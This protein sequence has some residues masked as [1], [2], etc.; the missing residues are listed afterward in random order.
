[1]TEDTTQSPKDTG[2]DSFERRFV[3]HIAQRC[4]DPGSRALLRRGYRKTPDT[5][6]T[7]HRFVV[8]W[9]DARHD[10]DR[11]YAT[12]SWIALFGTGRKDLTFGVA[13]RKTAALPGNNYS[14]FEKRLSDL[15]RTTPEILLRDRLPRLLKQMEHGNHLPDMALLLADLRSW[16]FR[17]DR[18]F[19]AWM[20]DFYSSDSQ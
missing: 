17:K 12:A 16:N 19:R 18:V 11:Y 2:K 5:A 4:T 6:H 20:T 1:M 3:D 13:V 7:L 15:I 14:A 10:A 8:P 9:V